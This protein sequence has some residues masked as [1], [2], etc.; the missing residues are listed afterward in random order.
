MDFL[1]TF[2]AL[3]GIQIWELIMQSKYKF[4]HNNDRTCDRVLGD[5]LPVLFSALGFCLFGPLLFVVCR[6]VDF[7]LALY[8]P[9]LVQ[10]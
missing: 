8:L 6:L 7:V 4:T 2:Y 10:F 5:A 3:S 9:L 1:N